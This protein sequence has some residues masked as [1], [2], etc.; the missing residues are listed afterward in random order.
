MDFQNELD[1]LIKK[2][3]DQIKDLGIT[4]GA[5]QVFSFLLDDAKR[6][7][8]IAEAPA[9]AIDGEVVK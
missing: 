1:S 5:I 7:K 8:E 3:E 9:E 2:R 4:E 6:K